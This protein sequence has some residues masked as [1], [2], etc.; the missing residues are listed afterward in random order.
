[1]DIV[2]RPSTIREQTRPGDQRN[3]VHKRILGGITGLIGGGPAG[4]IAGFIGGGSTPTSPRF[5]IQPFAPPTTT[6][7]PG[8]V[9]R[10]GRCVPAVTSRGFIPGMPFP[11]LPELPT[12]FGPVETPFPQT[13]DDPFGPAVRGQYGAALLPQLMQGVTRR[14][15]KGSILGTDKLCYNRRDITNKERLWP[16]GRRPLLTGGEM[17]CISVASSA[18]KKLERK[19][20]QLQSMGML[21]KPSSGRRAKAIAP[22]HHSHVAHN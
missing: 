2:S 12:P 5:P 1:M 11:G 16:V 19:T 18:A 9:S 22:G 8:F 3:F 14:C 7:A 17:R 6:C 10:G 4:G 21:K 15:P 20:K 13:G